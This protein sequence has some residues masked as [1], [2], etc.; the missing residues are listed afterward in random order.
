MQC[1]ECG[2]KEIF[3]DGVCIDC[4]RKT[5][6][7]TSGPEIIDIPFCSHCGSYKYKNTWSS[8]IFSEILKIYVKH[9]FKI[10]ND[11]K[12]IDINT[13][14]EDIDQGKKCNIYITGHIEDLEITETHEVLVRLKKTVCDVCSKQYGGYYE[15]IIQIRAEDRKLTEKELKNIESMVFNT[16]EDTHAKGNRGLFVT[17]YGLEH[18]GIDFFISDKNVGLNLAKKIYAQYGGIIKQSSKDKGMKDSRQIKIMTYLVRI[19]SFRKN[20]FVKIGKTFFYVVSIKGHTIKMINL[21]NWDE[22]IEDLKNIQKA[23]V[24][25][26]NELI[27]EMILVSQTKEEVQIMNEKNYQIIN[28]KK[29]KSI[30]FKDKEIK[31][32]KLEGTVFLFLEKQK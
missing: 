18:G 16:I 31:T 28:V 13:E 12:N 30:N 29:P 21:A 1:V 23:N 11:F 9:L 15:A 2:Q 32:V 4:Y 26:G 24:I 8:Q 27:K 17:D 5:H 20:D 3:K 25:G 14:C 7:F 22:I 19:P 6:S 10:K